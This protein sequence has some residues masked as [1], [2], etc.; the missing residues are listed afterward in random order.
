VLIVTAG[1]AVVDVHIVRD[2][3]DDPTSKV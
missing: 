3:R 2:P 1:G